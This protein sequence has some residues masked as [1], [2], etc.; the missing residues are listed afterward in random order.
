MVKDN[1]TFFNII[2]HQNLT[3]SSSTLPK[4]L[5]Q[6]KLAS[7]LLKV[8]MYNKLFVRK[9]NRQFQNVIGKEK[10]PNTIVNF[11]SADGYYVLLINYETL[12]FVL[13]LKASSFFVGKF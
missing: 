9:G 8:K 3:K 12:V 1:V 11:M 6:T 2:F 5:I 13:V 7:Q 10:K 4:L